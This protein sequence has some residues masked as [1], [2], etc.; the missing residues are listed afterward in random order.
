M[1]LIF[2]MGCTSQ[3]TTAAS[4]LL[5]TSPVLTTASFI[6]LDS[7]RWQLQTYIDPKG[8]PTELLP[9]SQITIAF[10]TGQMVGLAGC[11]SY[12]T[13]YQVSSAQLTVSPVSITEKYCTAPGGLMQQE[14]QYLH[15]LQSVQGFKIVDLRLQLLGNAGQTL[16]TYTPLP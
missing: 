6:T 8:N 14:S 15:V 5:L 11:N 2:S 9:G 4:P 13:S 10:Q 7:T 1:L 16:L 3:A 12:F